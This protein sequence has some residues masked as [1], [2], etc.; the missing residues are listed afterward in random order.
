MS[1]F[2]FDSLPA[3]IPSPPCRHKP[4]CCALQM[5]QLHQRLSDIHPHF[6][7]TPLP[8]AVSSCGLGRALQILPVS[9]LAADVASTSDICAGAACIGNGRGGAADSRGAGG[10][11]NADSAAHHLHRRPAAHVSFIGLTPAWAALSAIS[12]RMRERSAETHSCCWDLQVHAIL[13]AA[14]QRRCRIC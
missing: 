7:H 9:T 10:A 8:E 3:T 13:G 12:S 11:H 6:A 4:G 14:R 1:H 5:H 2:L